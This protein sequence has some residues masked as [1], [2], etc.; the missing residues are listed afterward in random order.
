MLNGT[1]NF[2][3]NVFIIFSVS[4]LS[5]N[6]ADHHQ[7]FMTVFDG[8]PVFSS[9]HAILIFQSFQIQNF[10]SR[11]MAVANNFSIFHPNICSINGF[12]NSVCIRC[13]MTLWGFATYPSDVINSVQSRN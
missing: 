8:Q 4:I 2:S 13:F 5:F 11:S 1:V 3:D 12:S 7:F 6:N 10:F 9:I